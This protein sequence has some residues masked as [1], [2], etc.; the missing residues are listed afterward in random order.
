MMNNAKKKVVLIVQART[1]STRLK[2]KILKEVFGIPILSLLIERL[3]FCKRVDQIVIATTINK[4]DDIIE[5]VAKQN[6]VDFFRGSEDDLLDRHYKAGM[7]FNADIIIKVPSDC[8]LADPSII[9][10]AIQYYL[11]NETEFD[12]VS[13]YHP[14]TFP[15]GLDVEVIPIEIL[16]IAWM[17]AEKYYEREHLTPYIWDQ[18]EKFR[19]GNITNNENLFMTER[20]TLDYQEDYTFIKTVYEHLYRKGDIFHMSDVLDL[21]HKCPEI[22]EINHKYAGINW[23]R[24]L[25]DNLRTV[26]RYLYKKENNNLKL[27]NSI[28]ILNKSKKIIPCA[29]QTLSKGYTQWSVG[30]CPL[31]IESAKGCEVTDVDGNVYID[32]AMGL[33]PFILGYSDPD[34]NEAVS[35]QLEKGTM[36]TLPHPLEIKAAELIIE[37]VP[38]AEMVR[39]GKNGSD[40]TSGAVKVARAY[41]GKEK[42]IICGYHGWQDWYIVSTE[43]NKGIP[44]CMGDLVIPLEYNNIEMLEN[45]II[46]HKEEIAGLIMEPVCAAPPENNFLE[47]VRRITTENNIVL[48]FDEMFTGFRWSVG[49]AQ[50][51]FNVTPDLACF[52]KAIANGFP[53]SCIAGKKEIMETFEDVFFSF[54]YGGE[55]LSLAAIVATINKLKTCKVHE[56]VEKLGNYLIEETSKLINKHGIESYISIIGYPFKSV[57]NFNGNKDINPFELKTLFQQECAKRGILFIGYHEV[58]Y[59]HT[60]EHID[61]TLEAYDEIMYILK[62]AI[63]N[64]NVKNLLNGTIVTQIFKNVGDRSIK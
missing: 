52:G 32:Y 25:G 21:L 23:Y 33:G 5:E 8:P 62:D 49:G 56:H 22:R 48:I 24:N 46:E 45:I 15:D 6:G 44:K 34:V 36:F 16:K 51:Y 38:C 14:P 19:I 28:K 30:A 26:P 3:K 31:F 59:S 18:P 60:K 41:T 2:S 53:V 11:D 42:I 55:T 61:Y 40:V 10:K 37:N 12:Y 47:D 57:V 1:G 64:N 17:N 7:Q 29:T 50:E 4:A 9:D 27:D 20:W 39:F 58:S 35:E 54:T 63:N 13:N 43:R